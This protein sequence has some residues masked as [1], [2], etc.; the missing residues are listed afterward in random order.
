MHLSAATGIPTLGLFGPTDDKLYS[1]TG[2]NALF[3]RTPQSPKELM[4][5]PNFN[6]RTSST[7]MDTLTV[8]MVVNY[9]K[10]FLN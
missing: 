6:H 1:P 5:I 7:L 3:V 2:K 8:R 4:D 10:T 9:L